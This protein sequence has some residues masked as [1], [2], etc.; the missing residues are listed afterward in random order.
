[1][2]MGIIWMRYQIAGG[3]T[4]SVD[5]LDPFGNNL[6]DDRGRAETLDQQPKIVIFLLDE[7]PLH[8]KGVVGKNAEKQKR[9]SMRPLPYT[10]SILAALGNACQFV[11]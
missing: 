3:L 1:M 2:G 8:H 5:E 6:E 7:R 4:S 9:A 10:L 11:T